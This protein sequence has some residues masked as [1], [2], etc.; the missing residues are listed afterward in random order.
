MRLTNSANAATIDAVAVSTRTLIDEGTAALRVGDGAAARQ[1]FEATVADVRTGAALEGL[2]QARYLE[3]DFGAAVEVWEAAYKAYRDDDDSVGAVRVA[4]TLAGMYG[5]VLGDA[6]VMRGWL[7]AARHVDAA[8]ALLRS[9][10]A[11]DRPVRKE[12]GL[13]TRREAEVLDLL[14]RGLSN[15]E[16]A[17]RLYISRKTVEHHVGNV[18][19]KLVLRSRAEAAAYAAR[20]ETSRRI[21]ELPDV[22][23]HGPTSCWL[24]SDGS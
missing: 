13:L 20:E 1:A 3:R 22:R 15:P 4:R 12:P 16:I 14:G 11:R 8:A 2:A 5:S 23:A 21:G 24:R 17:D 10:G 18:L 7:R 6:A 9:L 19:A